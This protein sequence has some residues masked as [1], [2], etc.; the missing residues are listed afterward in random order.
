M[1]GGEDSP[2]QYR[3]EIHFA[4]MSNSVSKRGT[5]AGVTIFHS[6]PYQ[7]TVPKK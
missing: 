4:K 3:V 6:I 7:E 1:T 2:T 5:V